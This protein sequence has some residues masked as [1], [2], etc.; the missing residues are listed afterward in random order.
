MKCPS[1]VQFFRN[2]SLG[3]F[4]LFLLLFCFIFA[5]CHYLG[6]AQRYRIPASLLRSF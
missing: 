3:D 6:E 4:D 1:A 5:V 2:Q